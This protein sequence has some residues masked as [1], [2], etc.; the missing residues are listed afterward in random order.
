[1]AIDNLVE[2]VGRVR[3]RRFQSG[4]SN[5][6]VAPMRAKALPIVRLRRQQ[7]KRLRCKG[8]NDVHILQQARRARCGNREALR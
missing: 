3:V 2:M 8:L 5:V 4:S 7:E 1:L 6:P